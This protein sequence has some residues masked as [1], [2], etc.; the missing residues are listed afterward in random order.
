MKE[1]FN[2]QEYINNYNKKNY[3]NISCRIKEEQKQEF[4]NL[5]K[6][7]GFKSYNDFITKCIEIMKSENN[8]ITK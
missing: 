3:K 4:D 8:N 1:E 5:I 6:K 2:Q 7:N